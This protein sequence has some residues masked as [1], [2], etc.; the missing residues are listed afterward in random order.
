MDPKICH[1][2]TGGWVGGEEGVFFSCL[3]SEMKAYFPTLPVLPV[4]NQ[5]VSRG[6]TLWKRLEW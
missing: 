3:L 1:G 5:I 2:C 6:A 4:Y